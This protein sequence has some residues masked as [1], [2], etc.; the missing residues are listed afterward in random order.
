[1]S[2]KCHP[3]YPCG[4]PHEFRQLH[5]EHTGLLVVADMSTIKPLVGLIRERPT[6]RDLHANTYQAA[7]RA[8]L[9]KLD[10]L[11]ELDC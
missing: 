5:Q 6:N 9:I 8:R 2:L 3:P 10:R 7:E 1:M 4:W 11:D